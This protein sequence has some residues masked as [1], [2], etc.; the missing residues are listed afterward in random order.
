MLTYERERSGVLL[1]YRVFLV[2]LCVVPSYRG[3]LFELVDV[4]VDTF[5]VKV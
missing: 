5:R 2:D 3:F 1:D 4:Y